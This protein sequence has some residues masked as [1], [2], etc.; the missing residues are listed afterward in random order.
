MKI[1]KIPHRWNVS[2]CAAI[3]IQRRLASQI[4]CRADPGPFRFI[5]GIDCAFSADGKNCIAGV[6]LWDAQEKC[7]IE[8]AVAMRPLRFPYVPGLLS[9]REAPAILAAL[10]KLRGGPD[11]L[12][13][14]GQGFAHPRRVGI[15]CHVGLLANK[16]TVG[17]A[18]SRLCGEH[19]EPP[20]ARGSR[21]ELFHRGEIVGSVLRTQDG[22]NPVYVSVGHRLDQETAEQIVLACATKYRLPEPTRLADQLVARI[23]RAG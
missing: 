18:K 15:A 9:F 14:D 22:V 21:A 7:V 5:A 11:A 6:V 12:M 1:P 19:A 20:R 13:C 4:S 16:P 23:K 3:A 2:P 10:R 8:E 17:C